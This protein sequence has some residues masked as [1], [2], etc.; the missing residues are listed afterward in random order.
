MV[1][2]DTTIPA[3]VCGVYCMT[4]NPDHKDQASHVHQVEA[5]LLVCVAS[6]AMLHNQLYRHSHIDTLL[7]TI[8]ASMLRRLVSLSIVVVQAVLAWSFFTRPCEVGV[9][10]HARVTAHLSAD[11]TRCIPS[12]TLL[13]AC[14]ECIQGS[15]ETDK[16]VCCRR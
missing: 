2:T 5:R 15:R 10:R 3:I 16:A 13:M 6:D 4:Q 12:T 14:I 8:Q 11:L 9:T 7:H 1:C